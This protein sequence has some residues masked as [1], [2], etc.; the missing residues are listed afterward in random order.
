MTRQDRERTI[1]LWMDRIERSRLS[2][3]AY[4]SRYDVPFTRMQYYRYLKGVSEGG[5]EALHDGRAWGNRRRVHVQ[6]EGFL[7]GYVAAHPQTD[8]TELCGVLAKQFG[9]ELTKSG[10]SR[11]LKRLGCSL[12]VR[13]YEEH[14]EEYYTACGGFELVVGLACHSLRRIA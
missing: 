6:A 9:I 12:G 14:V 8:L 1:R 2:V 10:M 3:A 13:Q 7:S 4:F 5:V 11:C